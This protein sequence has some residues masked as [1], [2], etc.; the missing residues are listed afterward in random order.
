M[1]QLEQTLSMRRIRVSDDVRFLTIGQVK[2]RYGNVSDMWIWRRLRD[3]AFP[4]PVRF[5]GP[6][7]VR[8]WVLSDLERWERA[9]LTQSSGTQVRENPFE[10]VE[11]EELHKPTRQQE[12]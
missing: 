2:R 6:T 5:G 9:R 3:H 4:K 1:S 12:R 7:S 10:F 11:S 8:H